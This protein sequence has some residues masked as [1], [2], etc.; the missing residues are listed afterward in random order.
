MKP[1]RVFYLA[2]GAPTNTVCPWT[3]LRD[4][5]ADD[6]D[7]DMDIDTDAPASY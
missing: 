1:A 4:A 5:F 6:F 3:H 2:A 7:D